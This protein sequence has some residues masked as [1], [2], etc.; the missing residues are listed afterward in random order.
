MAAAFMRLR[1][2]C[3]VFVA[4]MIIL[5]S[6]VPMSA[7]SSGTATATSISTA[8]RYS[9]CAKLNA[10]YRHGVGRKGAVDHVSGHTR[11]VR[12]FTVNTALYNANKARDRDH[13]GIACEKL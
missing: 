6:A 4:A 1:G 13:D 2:P 10:V 7:A 3:A 8:V 12:N 9:N 11:P 5:T